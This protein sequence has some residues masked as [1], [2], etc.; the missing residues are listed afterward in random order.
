MAG[1]DEKTGQGADLSRM[2]RGAGLCA[3]DGLTV[4]GRAGGGGP[5]GL[6][7]G[8]DAADLCGDGAF[9]AGADP[10]P[11]VEPAI[12]RLPLAMQAAGAAVVAV[13]VGAMPGWA[14]HPAIVAGL[15]ATG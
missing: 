11:G 4:A 7:A 9:R 1:E 14:L 3:G 6:R 13:L 15:V 8:G 12:H 10:Q 2:L 5:R